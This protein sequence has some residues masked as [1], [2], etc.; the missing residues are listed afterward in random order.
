M[1]VKRLLFLLFLTGWLCF[2]GREISIA[3]AE[4]GDEAGMQRVALLHFNFIEHGVEENIAKLEQGI[5]LAGDRGAKFI[6]T[7]EM[8]VQGYHF[9]RFGRA[10]SVV[11]NI[12]EQISGIMA[13]AEKYQAYIFLGTA[14]LDRPGAKPYNSCLAIGPQGKIIGRHDKLS[15]HSLSEKW[16]DEG[17]GNHAVDCGGIKIGMLVCADAWFDENAEAL[18]KLGAEAVVISAAWP[19]GFGGPPENA[20]MRCSKAS[21][22]LPVIVCNQTG[23]D[24]HLN[25]NIAMS[26]LITNGELRMSY[27]SPDEA[28]LLAD[29]DLKSGTVSQREFEVVRLSDKC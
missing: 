4:N 2:G 21:G 28:L 10:Y 8:A 11:D 27:S 6:V 7:P 16:A 18:K 1:R 15:I 12:E 20:W 5:R 3:N 29:I 14:V 26:A 23:Y 9:M 17:K 13:L 25:C 22:M 24:G 19:P